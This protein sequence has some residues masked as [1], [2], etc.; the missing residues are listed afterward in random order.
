MQTVVLISL[1]V[2]GAY[3]KFTLGQMGLWELAT[4]LIYAAAAGEA[5]G[6]VSRLRTW[7]E[8]LRAGMPR[9]GEGG[10]VKAA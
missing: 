10:M 9:A 5:N 3:L 4:L 7:A 6:A 8:N 2:I 1:R